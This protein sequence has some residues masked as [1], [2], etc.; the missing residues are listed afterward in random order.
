MPIILCRM[1]KAPSILKI[2]FSVAELY[3][4][5]KQTIAEMIDVNK[6]PELLTLRVEIDGGTLSKASQQIA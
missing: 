3:K 2:T 4:V 5:I 6:L 1:Q